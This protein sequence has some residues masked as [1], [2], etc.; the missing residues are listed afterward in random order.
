MDKII[1][2]LRKKDIFNSK[3][4]AFSRISILKKFNSPIYIVQAFTSTRKLSFPIESG[5][6]NFFL[7][8][9]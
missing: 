3:F 5:V 6:I 9:F 1:R 7:L 2:L 4:L 8:Y